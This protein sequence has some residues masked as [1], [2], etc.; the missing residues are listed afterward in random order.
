MDRRETQDPPWHEVLFYRVGPEDV[1]RRL[2]AYLASQIS[3]WSRSRLQRLI[4]TEDVLVNKKPAKPSY[5]LRPNDEIEIELTLSQSESW[6][7]EDIPLDV[8]YEDESLLVINKPAGLVVHPAA[9][10]Q[11]GTLVNAL[12]FHFLQL[13]SSGGST[14]PGIVHRLDRDTSGLMLVAR[15]ES[16]LEDL[17]NQFRH[18]TVYK[19]YVALVHGQVKPE[20]GRI[21]QPL[22]RDPVNRTRIA[23]VKGGRSALSYFRVRRRY[24]RFTLLE[25]ELKTGRTHQI[26]VHLAWLNHPVVG[27]DTYGGGRDNSV[28]DTKLRSQLRNLGRHFL[29]A[30]KLHFTHPVTKELMKFEAALPAELQSFLLEVEAAEKSKPKEWAQSD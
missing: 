9:G 21:E 10:I 1:D 25:V 4:E 27:D 5:K 11:S 22:A 29:H 19:S 6:A 28:L 13:P 15:T 2:D 14:R 17:A 24:Q 8:V 12:A 16:A 20:A 23:V 3:S 7:P 30:E 26:R 18:R